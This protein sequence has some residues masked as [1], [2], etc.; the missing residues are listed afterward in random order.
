LRGI[1]LLGLTAVLGDAVAGQGIEAILKDVYGERSKTKSVEDLLEE[2]QDLPITD[3]L[4][5]KLK[6]ELSP[7]TRNTNTAVSAGSTTVE[8]VSE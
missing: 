4:K 8:I 2:I 3:E 7:E 1:D 6:N 5:L